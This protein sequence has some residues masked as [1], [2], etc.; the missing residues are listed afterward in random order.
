MKRL[1][2]LALLLAGCSSPELHLAPGVPFRLRPPAEGPTLFVNQEV[3]FTLPD[4]KSETA[5]ATVENRDGRLIIVAGSPL[6]QTLMVIKVQ[7]RETTVDARVPIPGD[8]DPR[9]LAGLVQLC[10][11]PLDSLRRG[12]G[13]P[14]TAVE[15]TGS[16]RTLLRKGRPVWVVTYEPKRILMENPS[17]RL[18]VQ[19]RTLVE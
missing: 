7:G 19:I 12:L 10:L 1:L 4:G 13:G 2:L 3:V 16:V 5:L 14:D 8:L 6:G 11:W 17:L 9:T 15:Q 18:K